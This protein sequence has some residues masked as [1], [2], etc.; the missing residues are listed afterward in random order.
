MARIGLVLSGGGA[1]AAYQAGAVNALSEI[2]GSK[3]SPFTVMAGLS[4]GAINCAALASGADD[5]PRAARRLTE[6]WMSLTPQAVYRTDVPKLTTLGVRW[7][8]DLTTGGTL[9]ESRANHLLDTT[10]LRELLTREID[11]TRLRTLV[12][13]GHLHGVALSAT[14]YFTGT[15]V[16]FFDGAP[17]IEPWARHDRIARRTALRVEHVL[18]SSA[19]PIFFPPVSVDGSPFGDGGVR[20]TTPISPAIHLGAERIV[21]IGIR[22]GRSRDQTLA[23]NREAHDERVSLARIG[24]VVL[25]GLFLDSLDNDLERLHRIN[26]TLSLIPEEVRRGSPDLLRPIPA[27]ALRPS[28]D[29]GRLAVD[30]HQHFPSMLKHLLR[31]I[32]ASGE[33]GWDLLSY[34]AFQPGYVSKLIELGYEDTRARRAELETFLSASHEAALGMV[35]KAR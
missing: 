5:L 24:G 12:Q 21:T 23:L 4:A 15:T 29:L 30:E 11:M 25:N 3:A 13:S 1:R 14:S 33:A 9:G 26:R 22:Y 35:T 34:L 19:I 7:L 27:F 8:K 20:M 16:T 10:P 32:G 6:V 17:E 31:G 28:Q 2:V 18:A